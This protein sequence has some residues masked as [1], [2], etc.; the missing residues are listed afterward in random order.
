MAI[1]RSTR[2]TN[3]CFVVDHIIVHLQ[4]GC[5]EVARTN[6]SVIDFSCLFFLLLLLEL[7][8]LKFR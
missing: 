2:R 5:I 8:V 6:E 4:D 3:S 7:T 1:I